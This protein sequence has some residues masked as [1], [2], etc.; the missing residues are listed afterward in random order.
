[1]SDDDRT[2]RLVNTIYKLAHWSGTDISDLI[3]EGYLEEGD[4]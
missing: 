2:V 1:L 3:D 4:L